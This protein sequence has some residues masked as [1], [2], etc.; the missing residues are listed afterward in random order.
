MAKRSQVTASKLAQSRIA[1]GC[2]LYCGFTLQWPVRGKCSHCW[3][4]IRCAVLFCAVYY[5][6]L[7]TMLSLLRE[8]YSPPVVLD[9]S[10]SSVVF[11]LFTPVFTPSL[12]TPCFAVTYFVTCLTVALLWS[13]LTFVLVVAAC[14]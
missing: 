11:L 8:T 5:E 1:S 6:C 13:N 2:G 3:Q 9:L 12:F 7:L 10:G 4:V 14:I